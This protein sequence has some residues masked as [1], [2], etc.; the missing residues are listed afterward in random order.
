MEED[1]ARCQE[2]GFTDHLTKPVDFK[3]LETLM[4]GYLAA[5]DARAADVGAD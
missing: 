4:A 3:R 2:A 1:I 5:R